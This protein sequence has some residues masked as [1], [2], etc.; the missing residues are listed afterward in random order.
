MA[1]VVVWDNA[2]NAIILIQIISPSS[3]PSHLNS[4]YNLQ[5]QEEDYCFSRRRCYNY[6]NIARMNVRGKALVRLPAL[7]LHSL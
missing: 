7:L 1:R 6:V 4:H 2:G 3:Q 5:R